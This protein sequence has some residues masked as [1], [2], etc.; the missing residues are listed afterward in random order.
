MKH[1]EFLGVPGSGTTTLAAEVARVSSSTTLEDAV[2]ASIRAGGD[3]Q[4]TRIAARLSRSGT[5]V[6][7]RKALARSTDRFSALNRFLTASPETLEAVL[8]AQRAR[9]SR[10]RGQGRS[11]GWILNLM[12]AFQL[13]GEHLGEDEVL[14]I[15]EG[16]AQRSIALCG[17]GFTDDDRPLLERY[18]R[19]MP[20]PDAVILVDTPLEVC[21]SRLNARGWSERVAEMGVADRR[22]FLDQTASVVKTVIAYLE[23]TTTELVRVDGTAPTLATAGPLAANLLD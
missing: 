18:L 23:N 16:F 10:D 11:L 4:L 7:W 6:I 1:V 14:M 21:E 17:F 3:D 12:A 22:R 2:L 13:A 20:Q 15:D 8:G 19:S 9:T 5:S